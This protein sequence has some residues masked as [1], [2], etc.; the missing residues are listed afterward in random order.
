M[1]NLSIGKK[2][3][4]SFGAII[5]LAAI[6]SA[7][8]VIIITTIGSNFKFFHDDAFNCTQNADEILIN[9]NEA[10]RD[11]LYATLDPIFEESNA[12]LEQAQAYLDNA[13]A[14]VS[15]LSER[16]S[17]DP[18]DMTALT[19][20]I[21]AVKSAITNNIDLLTSTDITE[22]F[23]AYNELI[24]GLRI[25]IS[26]TAGKVKT[27]ELGYATDLYSESTHMISIGTIAMAAISLGCIV[28]GIVLALY[29]ARMFK[30]GIGDVTTAAEQMARGDFDINISY[31]SKDEVGVLGQ[32]MEHLADHSKSVISD[33]GVHLE[34]VANG[35]LNSETEHEDLYIGVFNP[36]LTSYNSFRAKL[37]ET[38]ANIAEAADQVTSGSEQV[39]QGAQALSQGATEQAASVEELSATINVIAEMITANA[40]DATEANNK[41][42]LAGSE[43]ANANTKMGELVNAMDNIREFSGKIEEIIKT[44][45]DIAFQ[46]N[47]LALNAAIEAARAGEAGKGFA[48]V[49]DEVRN[50]AAKSG[51]AAQNT[52]VLI[53]DTL[54][55]IDKGNSLVNEVAEDMNSV[56][57]SASAVAEING[58]IAE[59]SNGAADAISQVTTGIDQI[60][61]VV[62]T[63]SA[64]SEQSAAASEQLSG[65]AS[66][67]N[68]LISEFT[69]K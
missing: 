26:D 60:S 27:Q 51:E 64:T 35:N 48:V 43:L 53:K 13:L 58:K 54:D 63:N 55:A 40:T 11:V 66:M 29:V 6:L 12:R 67:L 41:T 57:A 44:I 7:T 21:T 4:V 23:A 38:M 65:Q 32:C 33:L 46:T 8:G 18:A 49:A 52:D 20:D 59:A 3:L 9:V 37:K 10:T 30:H 50:L 25:S 17:G 2:L 39:A 68:E 24:Y 34:D 61:D 5:L 1:K 42:A 62:Q 56:A 69:I 45:E 19:N 16:Y 31:K 28:L 22:A 15:E 36:I 47:I 14:A